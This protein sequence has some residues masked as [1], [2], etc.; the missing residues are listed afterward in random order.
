MVERLSAFGSG[1]DPDPGIE[2]LI[3]LPA[4]SL[5]VSLP[6]ILSVSLMNKLKKKSKE[7]F[8]FP[9]HR[10]RNRLRKIKKLV[11][12]HIASK[13]IFHQS[14]PVFSQTLA[15]ILCTTFSIS[16]PHLYY[17]WLTNLFKS[18]SFFT[19]VNVI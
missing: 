13:Y 9:F 3:G 2:S 6:L 17:F 5:P 16:T 11:Q 15:N 1:H 4:W 8:L 12:D 18:V 10:P 7:I 14:P 19:L